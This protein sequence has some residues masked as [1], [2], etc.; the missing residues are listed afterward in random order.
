MF[1]SFCRFSQGTCLSEDPGSSTLALAWRSPQTG[2]NRIELLAWHKIQSC[3]A[4]E[5]S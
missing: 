5:E 3:Q 2:S 4:T 1:T